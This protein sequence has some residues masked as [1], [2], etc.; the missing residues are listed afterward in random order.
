[1]GIP[2]LIKLFEA[3]SI[4]CGLLAAFIEVIDKDCG[5]LRELFRLTLTLAMFPR[6]E[7][8]PFVFATFILDGPILICIPGIL[9]C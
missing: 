8:V 3:A 7:L 9:M 1:M 2:T 4:P 5:E 6:F